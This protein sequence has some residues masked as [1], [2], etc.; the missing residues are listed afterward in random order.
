MPVSTFASA[1][2]EK[3]KL[4]TNINEANAQFRIATW[5]NSVNQFLKNA[6]VVDPTKNAMYT[7]ISAFETGGF[8]SRKSKFVDDLNL[9]NIKFINNNKIQKATK[10]RKASD[11]GY[12]AKYNTWQDGVNDAIRV[13]N[14]GGPGAPANATSVSDLVLR[15]QRNN[16]FGKG[17]PTSYLKGL[18]FYLKN[19]PVWQQ[20]ITDADN[21]VNLYQ[22]MDV[23]A[24]DPWAKQD[25][26]NIKEKP[27]DWWDR[28]P[29][30][31][32]GGII[33]AGSLV[34]ISAV[35]K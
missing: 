33:A 13:L 14:I 20:A 21:K 6:G 29:W 31:I 24:S 9:F 16:Y 5:A 18:Q 10:G 2:I 15:L 12:F 8:D 7:A 11:G 3:K 25:R 22:G 4:D 35:K 26:S 27:K 23:N 19:I 1:A 30:Y 34:L 28:Q 32:K 17:D